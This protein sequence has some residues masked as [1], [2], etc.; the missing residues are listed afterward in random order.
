MALA[1]V[2]AAAAHPALTGPAMMDA[3]A[4]LMKAKRHS[5]SQAKGDL[6]RKRSGLIL[7]HPFNQLRMHTATA[8][9]GWA[10]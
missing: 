7:N 2:P 1:P 9:G 3:R 6:E 4:P 10:S 8:P 5:P